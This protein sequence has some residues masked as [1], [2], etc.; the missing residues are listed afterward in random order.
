MTAF[1]FVVDWSAIDAKADLDAAERALCGFAPAGWQRLNAAG[2]SATH[3]G[4]CAAGANIDASR[5]VLLLDGRLSSQARQNLQARLAAGSKLASTNDADLIALAWAQ[6]RE[7]V[8]DWLDGDFALA[9]FET[10]AQQ[11]WLLRSRRGGRALHFIRDGARLIVATR[12]SAALRAAGLALQERAESTAA[13]F[14]LRAPPPGCAYF[15]GVA[16]VVPGQWHRFDV[17]SSIQGWIASPSPLLLPHFADD[18]DAM[19]AWSGLL[20]EC[21]I[22]AIADYRQPGVMLSGGLDSSALAALTATGRP[23]LRAFSWALPDTPEADESIWIGATC[24]HLEIASEVY[25]GRDDWPLARLGNWPVEDDGPPGNPYRWLQL[26]LFARAAAAGCDALVTGN[27]GDHLYP[28][29][30]DWLRSGIEDRG[31]RWALGQELRL[32]GGHGVAALWRDAGWRSLIRRA[33]GARKTWAAPAWMQ[34]QWQ[35]AL[36]ASHGSVPPSARADSDEAIQDAELGRRFH[37][38]FGIDMVTPYRDPRSIAFAAALPAHYQFRNAQAK[39]LTREAMRERLPESVRI[40]PK[41]GSLVPYFRKGLAGA[42]DQIKGLLD[43]PDARWRDYVQPSVLA[44][45]R[46]YL[47]GE[48]DLLLV[49]LCVSYEL[50]WRAHSGAGPAVLASTLNRCAVFEAVRD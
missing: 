45:A 22:E 30:A 16:A 19:S 1:A 44:T 6:W 23:D 46:Q 13:Y 38:M 43:A 37:S 47:A 40:R 14:A 15:A 25:A 31:W 7:A 8:F 36:L 17:A 21:A 10:F 18:R 4:S 5:W 35:Q 33:K 34:P 20:T 32:L 2:F 29:R 48:S 50:W 39:W 26:Q 42:S 27:F 28:E 24:R 11:L 9:I 3:A 12:A 49:W 41:A